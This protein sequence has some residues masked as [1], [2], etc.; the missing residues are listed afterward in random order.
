MW[1]LTSPPYLVPVQWEGAHEQGHDDLGHE[2]A[3][4]E[5]DGQQGHLAG[6]G[7]LD[8]AQLHV[9][10]LHDFWDLEHSGGRREQGEARGKQREAWGQGEGGGEE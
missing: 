9:D 2:R 5:R 10:G 8:V 7:L 6:P 1:W 3:G 4:Q